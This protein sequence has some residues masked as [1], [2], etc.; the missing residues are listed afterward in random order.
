MGFSLDVD[1]EMGESLIVSFL[2]EGLKALMIACNSFSFSDVFVEAIS[3]KI[4]SIA[5]GCDTLGKFTF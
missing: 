3:A 2:V 1:K 4:D 5:L